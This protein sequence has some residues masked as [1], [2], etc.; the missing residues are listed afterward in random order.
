MYAYTVERDHK[1]LCDPYY[2]PEEAEAF[3]AGYTTAIC[4]GLHTNI[5]EIVTYKL[6]DEV[7]VKEVAREIYS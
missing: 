4:C 7:N 5:C 2:K 1:P 3:A 6:S